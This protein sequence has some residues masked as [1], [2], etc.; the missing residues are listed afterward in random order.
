MRGRLYSYLLGAESPLLTPATLHLFCAACSDALE[1][2]VERVR[3]AV[4]LPVRIELRDAYDAACTE[5]TVRGW[6]EGCR[7]V[8]CCGAAVG[9]WRTR[10]AA[11]LLLWVEGRGTLVA[12]I[13]LR[14]A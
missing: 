10:C 11:V 5:L 7:A 4:A 8:G 3:T 9:V 13:M 12:A 2:L 6:L 1:E 14:L